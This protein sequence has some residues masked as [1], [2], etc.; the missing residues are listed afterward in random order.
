MTGET[1]TVRVEL[2]NRSYDILIGESLL[3][4][5]GEL[6]RPLMGAGRNKVFVIGD[7]NVVRLHGATLNT[8]LAA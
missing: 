7:E 6:I 5:A 4:R 8:A 1:Q 3:A 2:A